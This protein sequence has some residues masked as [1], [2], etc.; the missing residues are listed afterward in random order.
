MFVVFVD[1]FVYVLQFALGFEMA[2]T[3]VGLEK[4]MSA[5]GC[6]SGLFSMSV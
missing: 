2:L 5:N 1:A 4:F 3:K 6:F